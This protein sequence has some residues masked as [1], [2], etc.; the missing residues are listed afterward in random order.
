MKSPLDHLDKIEQVAVSPFL[1][2]RILH[3]IEQTSLQDLP[4][5]WAWTLVSFSVTCL[6]LS[7]FVVS[8]SLTNQSKVQGLEE[9]VNYI[10][11][12]TLYHD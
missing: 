7:M 12:N 6:V 5:P 10:P 8:S 1:Y 9:S 4:K 2:T 11:T 3:K